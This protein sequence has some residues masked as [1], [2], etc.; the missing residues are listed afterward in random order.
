MKVVPIGERDP[1]H[2]LE[3]DPVL[4]QL[5][6]VGG[7]ASFHDPAVVEAKVELAP[8]VFHG[9]LRILSVTEHGHAVL[10]FLAPWI[11]AI[12]LEPK[13][14]E[15]V[16]FLEILPGQGMKGGVVVI[17][18]SPG[19]Q[20]L[21]SFGPV[22]G[23]AEFFNES[24]FPGGQ[25]NGGGE[26]PEGEG[27]DG[28]NVHGLKFHFFIPFGKIIGRVAWL[29]VWRLRDGHAGRGWKSPWRHRG[30]PC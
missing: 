1:F 19:D 8:E 29:R 3:T 2:G 30:R 4:A 10:D 23:E 13:L 28:T 9:A 22:L 18:L 21:E 24:D 7:F 12:S 6:G 26:E 5:G 11:A 17:F 27:G 15:V 25:K 14:E 16:D 20:F